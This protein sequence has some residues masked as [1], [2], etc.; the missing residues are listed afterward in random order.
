MMTTEAIIESGMTFGPYSDGHCFYLEISQTLKKINKKASKGGGIQIAEF[1]LLRIKD[2]QVT[3][4]IIE[5][6][7]SSPQSTNQ[8]NFT[9]YINEIK[10]KFNNSLA[11]FVAIY[12]QRHPA[13]DSELSDHYRQLTLASVDFQLILVIK[14]S[15]EE[16]L[17]PLQDELKK[18]L[19]PTVKIWSLTP[20]SVSVVNEDGARRRGLVS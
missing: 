14:N 19:R 6:K 11:L 13:N 3:V 1:L 9:D 10:T 20:T 5:A 2:T 15:K 17:P 7:T 18:A 4:S 16:W 12:L 8:T